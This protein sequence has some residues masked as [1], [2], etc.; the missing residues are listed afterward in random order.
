MQRSQKRPAT[1]K[2]C[3]VFF[4]KGRCRM[5]Q[6]PAETKSAAPFQSI[7]AE[8][9]GCWIFSTAALRDEWIVRARYSLERTSALYLLALSMLKAR[10]RQTAI[11]HFLEAA[12]PLLASSR[13]EQTVLS[14]RYHLEDRPSIIEGIFCIKTE[15]P[16][17]LGPVS[18]LVPVP[19]ELR[20][21]LASISGNA[22][23]SRSCKIRGI[24]RRLSV[25]HR[26]RLLRKHAS[27]WQEVFT[28][29]S[30]IPVGNG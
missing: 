5:V 29:A 10:D 13:K 9:K 6:E 11:P 28:I 7:F 16:N 19:A 14:Q 24:R 4:A 21:S 17:A 27:S 1:L 23:L 22:K 18:E 2:H 20:D 15:E 8:L 25:K 3:A 12:L 30:A 26:V